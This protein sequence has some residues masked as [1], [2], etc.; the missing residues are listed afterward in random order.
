MSEYTF[1]VTVWIVGAASGMVRAAKRSEY[2]NLYDL[3]VVGLYSG[4]VSFGIIAFWIGGDSSHVGSEF[5]YLGFS[6]LLG[7]SGV[8]HERL[9][10]AIINRTTTAL[11]SAQSG[12]SDSDS[13]PNHGN[14]PA[15]SDSGRNEDSPRS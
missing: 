9:I 2:R 12:E 15:G 10:R 13:G 14:R 6:A 5:R 3:A 4:I 7:L 8:E 1:W 11:L